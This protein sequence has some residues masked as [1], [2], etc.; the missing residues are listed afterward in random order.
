M[1]IGDVTITT[2]RTVKQADRTD[3]R[4]NPVFITLE[5]AGLEEDNSDS[6]FDCVGLYRHADWFSDNTSSEYET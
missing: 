1:K 4:A 6:A 3:K 2:I 5:E